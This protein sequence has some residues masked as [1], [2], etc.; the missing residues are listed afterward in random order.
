M[1]QSYNLLTQLAPHLAQKLSKTVQQVLQYTGGL[2]LALTVLGLTCAR[3]ESLDRADE[4]KQRW[5]SSAT[6]RCV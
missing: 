2:P 4:S 3:R 6:L 1:V 5:L